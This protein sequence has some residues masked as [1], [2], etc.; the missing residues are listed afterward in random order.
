MDLTS[1]LV[2]NIPIK[3]VF[4]KFLI[5]SHINKNCLNYFENILKICREILK[6]YDITVPRMY[7]KY[8]NTTFWQ[9]SSSFI[10]KQRLHLFVLRVA[11]KL[12]AKAKNRNALVRF[13]GAMELQQFDYHECYKLLS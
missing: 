4:N 9:K 5:I 7:R 3:Y 11:S 6:C 8:S 2:L 1:N 12:H 10:M 13:R